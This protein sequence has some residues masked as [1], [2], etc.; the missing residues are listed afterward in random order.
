MLESRFSSAGVSGFSSAEAFERNLG[1]I[2]APEQRRLSDS[3]VAIAGCGGVGGAHAHTLA[4]LGV[5]RFR[6][7][8]PDTFSVAN[9]N[10]QI[11]ASVQ[12][13]G[14]NKAVVT[15]RMIRAINPG[16]SI[17]ILDGGLT[18]DNAAGFVRDAHAVVD[19]VDFFAMDARRRLFSAAWVEG[20]PALT[21]APLGFSGTLHVFAPGGMSFDEYF[22]LSDGQVPF[23]Q[24]VNFSIGLAPRAL[25]LPYLDLRTVDPVT[26]RGPSSILGCQMAACLLGAQTLRL[27]LGRG[28]VPLA[29]R[30]LQFDSYRQLLRTGYLRN[31]NR[32]AVQRLKRRV[33][34]RR[35]RQLGW[36]RSVRL[37]APVPG[38]EIGDL[39]KADGFGASGNGK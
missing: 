33:L 19:G 31:G 27:L 34:V 30:Y 25:H 14:L 29:P 11:G 36:T 12:T 2:S 16:A 28:Q 17:E 32:N 38:G 22:D 18:A 6:L 8:D 9:F 4:R 26:G 13:V 24:L 35:L 23:D 7:T 5:G 39:R 3:L 20:T 15:A 21:A 37:E 1:L 10:R